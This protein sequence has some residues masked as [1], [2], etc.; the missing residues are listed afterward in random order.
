MGLFGRKSFPGR[1]NSLGKGPEEGACQAY[2]K[3]REEGGVD[4]A[5]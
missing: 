3:N 1:G 2:L 5:E 4:R